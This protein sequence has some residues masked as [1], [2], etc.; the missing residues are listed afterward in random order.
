MDWFAYEQLDCAS[1]IHEF[2]RNDGW[3]QWMTWFSA[4]AS[5]VLALKTY[6]VEP[7]V[8]VVVQSDLNWTVAVRTQTVFVHLY[9]VSVIL[10]STEVQILPLHLSSDLWSLNGCN[11]EA[12]IF[13]YWERSIKLVCKRRD[14][15]SYA[16]TWWDVAAEITKFILYTQYSTLSTIHCGNGI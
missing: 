2:F 16:T 3:R 1:A 12:V 7:Q 5:S 8:L 9:T 6:S 4:A 15:T 14:V 11:V 10:K 13:S